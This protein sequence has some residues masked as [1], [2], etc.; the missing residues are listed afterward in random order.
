MQSFSIC[1]LLYYFLLFIVAEGMR[2][3]QRHQGQGVTGQANI[4]LSTPGPSSGQASQRNPPP[5]IGTGR[6]KP[7]TGPGSPRFGK[8]YHEM[9][10]SS[11]GKVLKGVAHTGIIANPHSDFDYP[12][13]SL[14]PGKKESGVISFFQ[15]TRHI[16]GDGP[17]QYM[18]RQQQDTREDMA[19]KA[20]SYAVG[21]RKHEH[22]SEDDKHTRN[23]IDVMSSNQHHPR[24]ALSRIME[25]DNQAKH[26]RPT[27]D[28]DAGKYHGH[29]VT[30]HFGPESPPKHSQSQ[31]ASTNTQHQQGEHNNPVTS[32][33]SHNFM[34]NYA[35]TQ[36]L[37]RSQSPSR[38]GGESSKRRR[39]D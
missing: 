30:F 10:L 35:S 18:Q 21:F 14:A 31:A 32:S 22:G 7:V 24:A 19:L 17:Y 11:G 38:D 4:N 20:K 23:M 13:I 37:F 29:L 6:M 5:K 15:H 12:K 16:P 28:V 25:A 39:I 27:V 2:P 8:A 1:Y 34:R 26:K 33:A 3:E 9:V 36:G